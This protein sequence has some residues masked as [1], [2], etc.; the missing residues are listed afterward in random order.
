MKQIQFNTDMF[1]TDQKGD[2]KR[3]TANVQVI[4][5]NLDNMHVVAHSPQSLVVDSIEFDSTW[6]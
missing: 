3:K 2:Y 5:I 4:F 1:K 6:V